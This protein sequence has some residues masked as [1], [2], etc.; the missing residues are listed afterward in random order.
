MKKSTHSKGFVLGI[1]LILG[2]A[3]LIMGFAGMIMSEM[4]FKSLSAEARWHI[5]EKAANYG[6]MD[7]IEQLIN[8]L[9][10]CDKLDNKILTVN[11]ALVTIKTWEAGTSCFIWAKATYQNS[12]YIKTAVITNI[13]TYSLAPVMVKRFSS[14]SL[15]GAASIV[16]CDSNCPSPAIITGNLTGNVTGQVVTSCP[17]N[18]KGI[19]SPITPVI[20]NKPEYLN[21]DFTDRLFYASN[22]RELLDKLSS[23]FRVS[24]SNGTPIGIVGRYTV[25]DNVPGGEFDV[26]QLTS[27]TN[28]SANRQTISCSNINIS[29][30][31]SLGK[32]KVTREGSSNV[33]LCNAIDFSPN[34]KIEFSNF[35]GGGVLFANEIVFKGDVNGVGPKGLTLIARNKAEDQANNINLKNVNVFAQ[36][37]YIDDNN[38]VWEGGV[39]YSG[40]AGV[41]NLNLDIRAGTKIGNQS[42]PVLIIT[43]N[44]VN[45]NG[46]GNAEIYGLIFATD[47]TNNFN[48]ANGDFKLY[49]VMVSNSLKNN[50]YN[51]NGN[52]DLYFRPDILE[53]LAL[54]YSSL[55]KLPDCSSKKNLVKSIFY[56]YQS[57]M[58]TY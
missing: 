14:F 3:I 20:D 31:S 9:T 52:F 58:G 47:E 38:F 44:N 53:K 51:A 2:V 11:G 41:G 6:V 23:E 40:G 28:C 43:D 18:P 48:T 4:G 19:L 21:V 50:I 39:I 36:N 56:L 15:G 35:E 26:C 5:V 17:N 55:V 12:R 16:N 10:T 8:G 49:G 57:K 37:I 30:D 25:I 7:S 33:A 22:R 13:N 34:A 29:W 24:L 32:Y 42:S 54:R 46:Q 45:I 27:V 1:V